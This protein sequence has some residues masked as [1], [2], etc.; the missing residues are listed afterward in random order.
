MRFMEDDIDISKLDQRIV[1]IK[2]R[3]EKLQTQKALLL[4]KEAKAILGDNFSVSLVLSILSNS[5]DTSS[6][7]QKEE[8]M[9]SARS[10]RERSTQ[11]KSKGNK[12]SRRNDSKNATEDFEA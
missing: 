1:Q 3:K 8:W 9:S 10:F 7:K 5:W 6:E 4:V 11:Q 12:N 2:K